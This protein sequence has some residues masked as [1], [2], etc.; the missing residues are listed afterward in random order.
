MHKDSI[1]S[2]DIL[3]KKSIEWKKNH[4]MET[5]IIKSVVYRDLKLAQTLNPEP[6]LAVPRKRTLAYGGL[7]WG[8][9]EST[10]AETPNEGAWMTVEESL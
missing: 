7:Q 1:G 4:Q 10:I 3:S 9:M 8:L 2:R 5:G 6:F